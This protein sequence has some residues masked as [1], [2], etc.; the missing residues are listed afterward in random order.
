MAKLNYIR[1]VHD[2]ST[3]AYLLIFKVGQS[4]NLSTLRLVLKNAS[5]E[6]IITLPNVQANKGDF[7]WINNLSDNQL[8]NYI[9][10]DSANSSR[11]R[12]FILILEIPD[13]TFEHYQRIIE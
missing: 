8:K 10:S 9:Q 11:T 5:K 6:T 4:C 12:T 1:T 7:V 13:F 2:E 3:G